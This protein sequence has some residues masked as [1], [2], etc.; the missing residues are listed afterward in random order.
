MSKYPFRTCPTCGANL[1][2][3]ERC[4]CCKTAPEQ[5]RSGAEYKNGYR[6]GYKHALDDVEAFIVALQDDKKN[7]I[8]FDPA[9][10]EQRH[11]REYIRCW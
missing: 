1:D 5:R 11:G 9:D 4:D 2:P 3:G 8:P 10:F 6:M 7:G